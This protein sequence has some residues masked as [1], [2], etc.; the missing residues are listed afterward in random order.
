MSAV[1][2]AMM[3]AAD[4]QPEQGAVPA[5]IAKAARFLVD[6]KSGKVADRGEDKI[7]AA[8][9]A[10]PARTD[11]IAMGRPTSQRIAAAHAAAQRALG[12]TAAAP[13][14][15]RQEPRLAAAPA[16]P[17][18]TAAR[19]TATAQPAAP[20]AAATRP[21]NSAAPAT[22]PAA[23]RRVVAQPAV[24]A[25]V[26]ATQPAAAPRPALSVQ[27]YLRELQFQVS[28]HNQNEVRQA[29][30]DVTPGEIERVS[31]VVAKLRGRYLA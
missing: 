14:A 13:V 5:A 28:G 7:G 15:Q 8:N 26:P 9:P 18:Q 11:H 21:A 1:A 4:G 10:A 3:D 27:Q 24:R 17:A 2:D 31:R 12:M 25:S 30:V 19:Q 23:A 6:L 29:L 22:A 16:A 20:A